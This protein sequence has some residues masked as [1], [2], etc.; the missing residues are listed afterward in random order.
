[1]PVTLL[2]P[3]PSILVLA[4]AFHCLATGVR[5]LQDRNLGVTSDLLDAYAALTA[6]YARALRDRISALPD[7]S[8][9]WPDIIDHL[10]ERL[11][12]AREEDI[13]LDPLDVLDQLAGRLLSL[14][15]LVL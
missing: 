15:R 7:S 4:D 3:S 1:M 11:R 2:R 9:A 14:E 5:Q 8:A 10:V 6:T 12:Q 13:L